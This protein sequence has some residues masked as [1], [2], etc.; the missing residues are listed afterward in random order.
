VEKMSEKLSPSFEKENIISQAHHVSSMDQLASLGEAGRLLSEIGTQVS[1]QIDQYNSGH[2]D[3]MLPKSPDEIMAQFADNRSFVILSAEKN[4]RVLFHGTVYRNFTPGQ[5]DAWGFQVVEFGSVITHPDFRSLGL[6]SYGCRSV[7]DHVKKEN[8]NTICLST[9]KQE[10]TLRVMSRAGLSPV[11][12]WKYPHLSFLTCTCDNC[13][14]RHG[15]SACPFR[16]TPKAS[17]P[18]RLLQLMDKSTPLGKIPCTLM[19][20]DLYLADLFENR[21]RELSRRFQLP[22]LEPGVISPGS[23]LMAQALFAKVEA[24]A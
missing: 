5:Q 1:S 2:P 3:E 19:L 17:T 18:P 10:N 6:G 7:V 13:S 12:Y 8:H 15:F 14:E 20:S 22:Q 21:C 9:V 24:Y 11:S 16:R 23:M 4:A